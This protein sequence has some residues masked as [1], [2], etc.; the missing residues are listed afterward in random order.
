MRYFH[1][2]ALFLLTLIL[3]TPAWA[4]PAANSRG[5][6]PTQVFVQIPERMDAVQMREQVVHTAFSQL[7]LSYQMGGVTPRQGFDCSGFTNWVYSMVGVNL[8]RTSREQFTRGIAINKADLQP[9]DL[10]FFRNG[11]SI[12]H[13]GVYVNNNC[14]IHSPNK[15]SEIK[16]SNLSSPGWAKT[17]AGARRIISP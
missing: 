8:P 6:D 14:F 9:G 5:A 13:V 15:N 2:S 17:Y 1:L 10:V 4:A 16:I 7:G 11:R 3:A 12:G